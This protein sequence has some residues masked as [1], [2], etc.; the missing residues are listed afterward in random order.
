MAAS[1]KNSIKMSM[2]TAKTEPFGRNTE[3]GN[4]GRIGLLTE[5]TRLTDSSSSN[6]N[7]FDG[8]AEPYSRSGPVQIR[9]ALAGVER[10]LEG[11]MANLQEPHPS[12]LNYEI[13]LEQLCAQCSVLE[14]RLDFCLDLTREPT[15]Q[16]LQVLEEDSSS[17]QS[18]M[19]SKSTV[20]MNN[21]SGSNARQTNSNGQPSSE[22]LS[23]VFSGQ[24]NRLISRAKKQLKRDFPNHVYGIL[25]DDDNESEL[26][27]SSDAQAL[28]TS[29][30]THGIISSSGHTNQ[31]SYLVSPHFSETSGH[32]RLS[33]YSSM[34]PSTT[35]ASM[36][37][38]HTGS[39]ITSMGSLGSPELNN[40]L[41]RIVTTPRNMDG[42][43][44]RPL[45]DFQGISSSVPGAFPSDSTEKAS[46]ACGTNSQS[47]T[48][49]SI[50]VAGLRTSDDTS[51]GTR[52]AS[53]A[54]TEN[55]NLNSHS[56]YSVMMQAGMDG[57]G[58]PSSASYTPSSKR[59]LAL[60]APFS[61]P[62]MPPSLSLSSFCRAKSGGMD[63]VLA[64][65]P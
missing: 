36:M 58:S 65:W 46:T 26:S 53:D 60:D 39:S 15:V 2:G 29:S 23:N 42:P 55:S 50:N 62:G 47:C 33:S 51:H 8:H 28:S 61:S 24:L 14:S 32:Q 64:S 22:A 37:Q 30:N 6:S 12:H 41:R 16:S 56:S 9:Q 48:V 63:A 11:I 38:R 49:D 21:S 5:Y 54:Q 59:R 19:P 43:G 13:L 31:N 52:S 3:H 40:L 20:S 1:R 34:S 18:S 57:K 35:Y 4:H 44:K 25:K 27:N 10:S 45:R 17:N 7:H